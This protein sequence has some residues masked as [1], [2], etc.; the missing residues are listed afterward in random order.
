MQSLILFDEQLAA[1]V[2]EFTSNSPLL[3]ALAKI[4][5]VGLVYLVPITLLVTWFTV[6]RKDTLRA[7]LA[8]V[9]AWEGLSK[10]VAMLIQR[11]RPSASL[12]GVKELVFHRPDNSF[13]SDHSAFLMAVAVSF[14]LAGHKK[15]GH[16]VLILAVLTGIFRV[17]IGVHFPGDIVAG[18]IVGALVAYL[19]QLIDEPLDRYLL[20]PLVNLARRFKL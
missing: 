3:S 8:G 16:F 18:W 6:S 4:G 2:Y 9:L 1:R 5:G 19:F 7:A 10:L 20:T 11:P 17:G 12:I 13:P 14:Y 15:L